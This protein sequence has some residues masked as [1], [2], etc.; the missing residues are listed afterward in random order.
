MY[1]ETINALCD[2]AEAKLTHQRLSLV[3][4]FVRS[5]LAG[6][7]VGAA[8]FLIF[9]IGGSL[10]K[11]YSPFVRMIMGICFGGALTIVVFAGSE[12]FTGSNLVLTLG[13]LT[14]RSSWSDL[15]ANWVWT[16]LGNLTGSLLL[17]VLVVGSGLIDTEKFT[18]VYNFVQKVCAAK[19]NI[20]ADQLIIR[21][22]L[23][24]WLVCLG[25]WMAARA[26]SET[27]KIILIWWCMFT[28]ITCGYEHSIANMFGLALGVLVPHG[29]KV[30]WSGYWYNVSLA[31]LG[32][33][34]GGAFFVAGMYW[35]GSAKAR[36]QAVL[37]TDPDAALGTNGKANSAFAGSSR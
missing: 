16:W 4:H 33:I 12:L 22:I 28:F 29:E 13:V 2:Q 3:G 32:N 8:I 17:A 35:M 30:S 31:T 26:K 18:A 27:A 25:V 11:D 19:M 24:N 10:D 1:T 34:I 37:A 14:K 20:P 7:Y 21:A 23:A 15:L 5:M 36:E 9:T 6:M